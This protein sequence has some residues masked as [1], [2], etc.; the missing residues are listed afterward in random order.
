M[1]SSSSSPSSASQSAST[2]AVA[3]PLACELNAPSEV[4]LSRAVPGEPTSLQALCMKEVLKG[5]AAMTIGQLTLILP[6]KTKHV[7][8][9]PSPL[10]PMSHMIVHD[11]KFFVR[12]SMFGHIG[13]GESY[14]SGDWDSPS[15]QTVVSWFILNN[16][17]AFLLEGSK[18]KR[19]YSNML[20]ILNRLRHNRRA[21]TVSNS[22]DNIHAHYDTGNEFFRLL[23][24][25]SMTYSSALF[26]HPEQSLSDAQIAKYESLCQKLRLQKEDKVLEIGSG[27]G[28]FACYAARKYGCQITS[29][30]ISN[31]QLK[32]AQQWAKHLGLDDQVN[33]IYKDYRHMTGQFDKIVSIEMIE[34]VGDKFYEPYFKQCRALLKPGGLLA[35]Q[36]IVCPDAR[37]EL[38]K[39]SVDFIQLYIFPGSLLPSLQRLT[40]ATRKVTDFS[41]VDMTDM[42]LS[43]AETLQRWDNNLKKNQTAVLAITNPDNDNKPRY[44]T[45]FIR[46]WH[47]YLMYCK[48][49][50]VTRNI[51]VV[52]L[53]YSGPNNLALA[54]DLEVVL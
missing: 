32:Y 26:T 17:D 18:R 41:L 40:Q 20:G 33:F 53:L 49:A 2:T 16:Q 9:E 54:P 36:A 29:I 50:F 51:T 34:A 24:D 48:A 28:G 37:Y 44:N 7:F 4:H 3:E 10:I 42:G 43:Y 15:I 13:A 39:G 23:L 5:L 52:Q 19:L 14:V 11:W 45:A 46:Q 47:Y 30:T 21:N 8:G 6:D 1:S 38:I 31:E 25:Q 27:W 12:L 35:I 22:S